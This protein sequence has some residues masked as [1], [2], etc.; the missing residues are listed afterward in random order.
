[1]GNPSPRYD[2]IVSNSS[3]TLTPF[4]DSDFLLLEEAD[5]FLAIVDDPTSPEVDEVLIMT[6]RG[7]FSFSNLFSIVI[8][9][10]H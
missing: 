1:Y 7:T 8:L 9:R 6:Q 2:P 3:S 4:G 5:T 10:L